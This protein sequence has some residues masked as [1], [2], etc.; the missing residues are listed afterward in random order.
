VFFSPRY[1]RYNPVSGD[2]LTGKRGADVYIRVPLGTVV[3]EQLSSTLQDFIVRMLFLMPS[4]V[5]M[6][7]ST[8]V[9]VDVDV[10]HSAHTLHS[11]LTKLTII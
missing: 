4:N 1:L 3:T 8:N 6:I 5:V 11:C 10:N 7:L 9:D 2:G